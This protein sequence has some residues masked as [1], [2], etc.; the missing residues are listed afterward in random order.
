[1]PFDSKKPSL[2]HL[3]YTIRDA[4]LTMRET[5]KDPNIALP[6]FTVATDRVDLKEMVIHHKYFDE[7]GP[8]A[9]YF[10]KPIFYNKYFVDN[11]AGKDTYKTAITL[12]LL[13]IICLALIQL[14]EVAM[15]CKE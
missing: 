14:S 9:Y 3:L 10:F 15:T 11:S 4:I 1:M 5:V 7:K 13:Q 8:K 2:D 12:Q 6:H